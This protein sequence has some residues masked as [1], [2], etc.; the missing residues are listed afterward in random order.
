MRTCNHCGRW[1]R[2][3]QAVRGHLKHCTVWNNSPAKAL[4]DLDPPPYVPPSRTTPAGGLAR[5]FN[6][7][8]HTGPSALGVCTACGT[9]STSMTV[10][11]CG[12]RIW[13]PPVV[14]PKQCPQCSRWSATERRVWNGRCDYCGAAMSEETLRH[15]LDELRARVESGEK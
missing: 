8:R 9:S 2:N 4:R 1:F 11:H 14:K 5:I 13:L 6:S 7:L 10:C 3:K 15:E 12:C